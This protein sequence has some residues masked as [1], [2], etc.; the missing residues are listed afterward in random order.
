MPQNRK[1]GISSR[2]VRLMI[3]NWALGWAVGFACAAA[4]L[5]SN[6]ANI[7]DLMFRSELMWQGLALLF[8]GFGF[9]FGGVVCATAVM[10]LPTD[11]DSWNGRGGLRAP[12]LL[13][14]YAFA[15][16]RAA[17]G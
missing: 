6:V 1:N 12:I 8:G 2:L 17:R 13:P 3:A 16:V 15:K 7:R 14:A 11:E 4:V 10:L 9:T 5:V